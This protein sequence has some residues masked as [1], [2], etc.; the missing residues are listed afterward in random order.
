MLSS[1]ISTCTSLQSTPQRAAAGWPHMKLQ[2]ALLSQWLN[3]VYRYSMVMYSSPMCKLTVVPF[4]FVSPVLQCTGFLFSWGVCRGEVRILKVFEL[5][6]YP[7]Q[8]K[9]GTFNMAAKEASEL[10]AKFSIPLS[11]SS[12]VQ[13]FSNH[14]VFTGKSLKYLMH[15]FLP[16][17]VV[18]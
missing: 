1:P 17:V 16:L 6:S 4:C 12:F 15:P 10:R 11:V 14:T 7:E 8:K 13:A 18:L 3:S 9:Y 2:G 5:D